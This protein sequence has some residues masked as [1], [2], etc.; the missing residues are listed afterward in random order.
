MFMKLFK[1]LYMHDLRRE[2]KLLHN[3]MHKA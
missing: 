2:H 1:Y 3:V